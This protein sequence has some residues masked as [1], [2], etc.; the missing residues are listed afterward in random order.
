MVYPLLRGIKNNSFEDGGYKIAS[1]K[2]EFQVQ[3]SHTI[4]ND[5]EKCFIFDDF[6]YFSVDIM[7]K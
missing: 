2:L 1:W 5:E 3:N 4:E 6:C 7:A